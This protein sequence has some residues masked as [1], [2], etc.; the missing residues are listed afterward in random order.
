MGITLYQK[1]LC[2][3]FWMKRQIYFFISSTA[4]AWFW[5]ISYTL[6][7]VEGMQKKHTETKREENRWKNYIRKYG[8]S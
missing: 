7:L 2:Q 3:F 1:R 4:F 8:T 5:E 6:E